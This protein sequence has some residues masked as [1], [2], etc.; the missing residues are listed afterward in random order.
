MQQSSYIIEV[1]NVSKYFGEKVALDNI[2]LNVKKGEF[3]T[4]LGPS[5]CGKTTLLRDVVRNI[6]NGIE[7]IAFKDNDIYVCNE[8]Y[9]REKDMA[10]IIQ[11]MNN[12]GW[13][14]NIELWCDSAEPDRIKMWKKA[15]FYLAKGVNKGGSAG[16]VK[17]QID[18]LKQRNI[19]VDPHCINA[20]KEMQQWKWKKDERTGEY[21]DDP[22]PVM[23]DAMAAL[24]YGIEGWR[25]VKKWLM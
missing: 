21:L 18:W 15:G 9:E 4:I 16:S 11:Q 24:R 14:R 12:E 1:Q 22:V 20:I 25:K 17:A 6:S 5:G 23:D 7:E 3:V 10:E 19:Y 8:L 13:R 2:N